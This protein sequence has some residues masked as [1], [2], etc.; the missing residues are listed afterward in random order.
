HV[1]A[2]DLAARFRIDR[3]GNIFVRDIKGA[4]QAGNQGVRVTTGNH[5]AGKDVAVLVH[6]AHAVAEQLSLALE[7]VVKEFRVAFAV[8][9]DGGIRDL[10]KVAAHAKR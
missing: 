6:H 1:D 4:G 2:E 8:I 3:A 7:A 5:A 10:R 9:A